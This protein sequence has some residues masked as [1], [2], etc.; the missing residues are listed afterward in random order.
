MPRIK[1]WN[2][3]VRDASG[4]VSASITEYVGIFSL[5]KSFSREDF[6]EERIRVKSDQLLRRREDVTR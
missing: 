4:A 2:R 6:A 1:R 3:D 5:L